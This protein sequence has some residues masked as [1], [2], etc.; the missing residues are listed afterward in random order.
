MGEGFTRMPPGFGAG[1]RGAAGAFGAGGAPMGGGG[2]P[3][4]GGPLPPPGGPPSEAAEGPGAEPGAMGGI[5]G[6]PPPLPGIPI[7]PGCMVRLAGTPCCMASPA[8]MCGM[9][10]PASEDWPPAAGGGVGKARGRAIIGGGAMV[11]VSFSVQAASSWATRCL[12]VWSSATRYGTI[13]E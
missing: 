13:L 4:P 11:G 3:I 10:G 1:D 9:P 8:S 6:G 2:A 5:A 7:P 12:S